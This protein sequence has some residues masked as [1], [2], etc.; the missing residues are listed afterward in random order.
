MT[1]LV[2]V[3]VLLVAVAA[4]VAVHTS[5]LNNPMQPPPFDTT[6]MQVWT[7]QRR[8]STA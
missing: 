2:E 5:I 3:A 8:E 4:H 7:A 1:E 6:S